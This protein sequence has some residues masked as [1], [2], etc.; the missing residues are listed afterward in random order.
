MIG[1][2][3]GPLERGRPCRDFPHCRNSRFD[4]VGIDRAGAGDKL[5]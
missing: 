1:A 2:V 3:T 5:L 4:L